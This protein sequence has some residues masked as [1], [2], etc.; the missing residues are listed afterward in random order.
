MRFLI[1]VL[2]IGLFAL[3]SVFGCS[4]V[5]ST[6]QF[7]NR[8]HLMIGID[9]SSSNKLIEDQKIAN[10]AALKIKDAVKTFSIGDAV[11]IRTF[12]SY[13]MSN[14]L[15]T[16]YKI[17][18]KEPPKKIAE[19]I[20]RFVKSLPLVVAEGRWPAGGTTHLVAFLEDESELIDCQNPN[21]EIWLFSDGIEA[22]PGVSPRALERGNIQLPKA[23]TSS[24]RGCAVTI[25]GIGQTHDK[26]PSRDKTRNLID[27]WNNWS[28][29]AGVEFKGYPSY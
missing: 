17:D 18:R 27:A 24:L 4:P 15:R 22:S 16:D 6:S 13:G 14:N 5:E 25:Y 11:Y 7:D 1:A 28:A 21:T 12:G 9:I 10:K 29:D 2:L 20:E 23:R 3:T 26:P 19:N 8:R